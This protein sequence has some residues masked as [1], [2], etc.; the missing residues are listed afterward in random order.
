MRFR[1]FDDA[2]AMM[3]ERVSYSVGGGFVVAAEG[4]EKAAAPAGPMGPMSFESGS[5]LLAP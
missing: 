5:E 1:A 3:I 4:T 2:D